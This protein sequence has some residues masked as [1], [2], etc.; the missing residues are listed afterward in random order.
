MKYKRQTVQKN[1]NEIRNPAI[2]TGNKFDEN[3]LDLDCKQ[4]RANA[5]YF[6]QC[7]I[8]NVKLL[9]NEKRLVGW[10]R[11]LVYEILVLFF[12]PFSLSSFLGCVQESH[13]VKI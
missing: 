11:S 8:F 13:V 9:K 5:R 1:K 3:R 12:F 4:H 10:L 6:V 2:F 7:G